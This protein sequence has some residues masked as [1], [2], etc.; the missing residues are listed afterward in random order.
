MF[1]NMKLLTYL[2]ILALAGCSSTATSPSQSATANSVNDEDIFG[3]ENS[4]FARIKETEEG[5]RFV[6]FSLENPTIKDQAWVNLRTQVPMWVISDIPCKQYPYKGDYRNMHWSC[7][8]NSEQ[9]MDRPFP[10]LFYVAFDEDEFEDALVEAFKHLKTDK[11]TALTEFK[12]IQSA[13]VLAAKY[14]RL[15]EQLNLSNR[16]SS[17]AQLSEAPSQRMAEFSDSKIYQDFNDLVNAM[18][19]L[20]ANVERREL[21]VSLAKSKINELV[22]K[23]FTNT[24][25]YQDLLAVHEV[26]NIPEFKNCT[27]IDTRNRFNEVFKQKLNESFNTALDNAGSWHEEKV[28]FN[29]YEKY[30]DYL[31]G[32]SQIKAIGEQIS[33]E[34]QNIKRQ[35]S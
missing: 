7:P 29:T 4:V 5:F 21:L 24:V 17:R 20:K 35:Y 27:T 34:Q 2:F 9:F 23:Q 33:K 8:R 19:E 28:V 30:I 26:I 13:K 16:F 11:N 31:D 3:Q 25:N 32:K 1:R 12:T 10:L 18:T 6:E 22:I 15:Q 14:D